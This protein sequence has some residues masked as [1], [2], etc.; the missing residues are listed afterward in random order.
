MDMSRTENSLKLP[1]KMARAG[2]WPDLIQRLD[3]FCCLEQYDTNKGLYCP[4]SN[5]HLDTW[6]K[7]ESFLYP[8]DQMRASCRIKNMMNVEIGGGH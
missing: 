6:L 5:Q 2:Q 1:N 7:H 3:E 8:G 4:P